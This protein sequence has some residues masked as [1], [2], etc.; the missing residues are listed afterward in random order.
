MDC[1]F[2]LL[3]VILQKKEENNQIWH[4]CRFIW[5]EEVE[6]PAAGTDKVTSIHQSRLR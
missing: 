6:A 1:C 2:M 4:K 3:F 5:W